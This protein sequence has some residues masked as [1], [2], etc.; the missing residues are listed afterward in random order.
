MSI[1]LDEGQRAIASQSRRA[2]DGTVSKDRLLGLLEQQGAFDHGFW[3]LARA[4][5]WP[6]L[7]VPEEYGGIGLGLVEMGLVAQATGAASAG[8]P[9][10]NTGYGAS[11]ALMASGNDALRNRWAPALATGE[12]IA[13]IAFAE[14][15]APLPLKPSV[16][17]CGGVLDGV[18]PGVVAGLQA[19]IAIVWA[20]S[21]GRPALALVELANVSREAVASFDNSRGYADVTFAS[22]SAMLLAQGDDARRCA[23]DVL[24]AMAVVTA[25]EQVGGAEHLLFVARDYANTRKAFGQPIGAFQS[26]KHKIAELYALVE[27]AR[28]NCI[29]AAA[30]DGGGDFLRAAAAARIS[31]TDAYD[32]AARDCVQVHGGI[33]VTWESGLHLHM[34]RARSLAIEHGNS[35]FW[36]DLLVEQLT[37]VAP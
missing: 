18:K 7:A 23:R 31:A 13:A 12:A 15:N 33:G 36:E 35:L 24:A 25:H 32:T 29:H 27:I 1:L 2:L 17:F 28:A 26:V 4:Q 22:T 34:R 20:L 8:A 37:G 30:R 21:E 10:L 9:F 19:D 5:G 6:G 3:D 11:R 14:G 16:T